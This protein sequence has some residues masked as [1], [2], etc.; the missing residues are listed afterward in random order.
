MSTRVPPAIIEMS[1][2]DTGVEVN[3][4]V[5]GGSSSSGPRR[6]TEQA[7]QGGDHKEGDAKTLLRGS[8]SRKE[9]VR[10]RDQEAKAAKKKNKAKWVA[11]YDAY[12]PEGKEDFDTSTQKD[13]EGKSMKCYP[14]YMVSTMELNAVTAHTAQIEIFMKLHWRF[15]DLGKAIDNGQIE[16]HDPSDSGRS[17]ADLTTEMKETGIRTGHLIRGALPRRTA[18]S[19]A[20]SESAGA[21]AEQL[22][23]AEPPL[24]TVRPFENQVE[25]AA[26]HITPCWTSYD[27]A[28]QVI[29]CQVH[30]AVKLKL[31][32]P[33]LV[34]YPLDRRAIKLVLARRMDRQFG[35]STKLL[36]KRPDWVKFG[37]AED[38]SVLT[39]RWP[40]V[41]GS[42]NLPLDLRKHPT[43]ERRGKERRGKDGEKA[44]VAT[45]Q[46]ADQGVFVYN[47]RVLLVLMERDPT[48]FLW[49]VVLPN[50]ILV[51]TAH[52]GMFMEFYADRDAQSVRGADVDADNKSLLSEQVGVGLAVILAVMAN[53]FVALQQ[54]LPAGLPFNTLADY[55]FVLSYSWVGLLLICY[56]GLFTGV[57][58]WDWSSTD[59]DYNID[60]LSFTIGAVLCALWALI[61]LGL[62]L[63]AKG[64]MCRTSWKHI[65]Q[66]ATDE[67]EDTATEWED[68]TLVTEDGQLDPN[69]PDHLDH[70]PSQRCPKRPAS[71]LRTD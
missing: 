24:S 47:D 17:A 52:A 8:S 65:V 54:D 62:V 22:F 71:T 56:T 30:L 58:R 53:K 61:C 12:S 49:N 36:A 3:N 7:M 66:T 59:R 55:F 2:T 10:D 35:A 69:K 29:T 60:H 68:D 20:D 45:G 25:G 21:P 11:E 4:P 16:L 48:N 37:Y 70:R 46:K 67:D 33:D 38:N 19:F 44:M 1:A 42:R 50:W 63:L 51:A 23:H 5:S 13:F 34:S 43:K 6:D 26:T 9:K 27:Q 41:A 40:D 57:M 18:S 15:N 39:V 28:K 14:F 32:N 64:G 31:P